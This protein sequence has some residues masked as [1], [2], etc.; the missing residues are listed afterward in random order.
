MAE[1]SSQAFRQRDGG[2]R[3]TRHITHRKAR[4]SSEWQ[5]FKKDLGKL[6]FRSS[7]TLDFDGI[8]PSNAII[9]GAE[10]DRRREEEEKEEEEEER[11]NAVGY[12][13]GVVVVGGDGDGGSGG[14]GGGAGGGDSRERVKR[15]R[16]R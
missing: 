8:S 7:R 14:G 15:T 9:G 12:D 4:Q 11:T 16:P 13:G 6:S 5:S 1:Q 3:N 10:N 2:G